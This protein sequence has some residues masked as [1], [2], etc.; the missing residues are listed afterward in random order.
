MLALSVKQPWA[1]CII[2]GT[3]DIENR[4]WLPG[5]AAGE[6]IAIHASRRPDHDAYRW[7]SRSG[8]IVPALD[9]LELGAIIGTVRVTGYTESSESFWFTGPVG[10]LLEDP[11]PCSPVPLSGRLGLWETSAL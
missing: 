7:L 1:W 8:V 3:K 9:D 4:S 11:V 6:R 10:W 5:R 2:H